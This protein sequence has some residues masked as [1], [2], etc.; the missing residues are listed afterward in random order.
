VPDSAFE[1]GIS[2]RDHID[3]NP[4]RDELAAQSLRIMDQGRRRRNRPRS[5]RRW[6]R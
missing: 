6:R 3:A 1:V 2:W 5:R 4:L